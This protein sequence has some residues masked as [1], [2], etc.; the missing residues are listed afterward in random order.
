MNGRSVPSDDPLPPGP[1]DKPAAADMHPPTPRHAGV[2]LCLVAA[3]VLCALFAVMLLPDNEYLG[4][5]QTRDS[6]MFH[7]TWLYERTHFDPA[8]IDVAIIGSSRLES[9][10]SPQVLAKSLSERLG[11]PVHVANLSLV[12]A[13]RDFTYL[14]AKGLLESHPE[15][16]VIVLSG[17]GDT[18]FSHPEFKVIAG[19][20]EILSAPVFIN[21]KY[22]ENLSYLPYRKLLIASESLF[23]ACSA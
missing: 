2:I 7:A 11:R 16:K 15:V 6:V 4:Y 5:Q 20:G 10:V 21:V 23:P 8:P 22:F 18:R 3:G 14:V 17:D 12:E 1:P 9:G 13:G 19:A